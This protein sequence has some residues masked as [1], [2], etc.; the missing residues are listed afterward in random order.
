MSPFRAVGSESSSVGMAG[1]GAAS[2]I[3]DGRALLR[4]DL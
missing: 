2:N 1:C 3:E 4:I